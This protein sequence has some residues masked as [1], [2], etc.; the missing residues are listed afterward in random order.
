MKDYL[1]EAID[2]LRYTP[3][4]SYSVLRHGI[5][6]RRKGDAIV[7]VIDSTDEEIPMAAAEAIIATGDARDE[8]VGALRDLLNFFREFDGPDVFDEINHPAADRA[9]ALIAKAGA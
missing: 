5:G 2:A 7:T 3:S 8:L 4:S 1:S 6:L 9:R